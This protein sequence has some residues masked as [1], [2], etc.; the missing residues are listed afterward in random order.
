MISTPMNI[1]TRFEQIPS[2]GH[3]MRCYIAQPEGSE[4]RPGLLLF[5]EAFGVNAHI[6]DV[7]ERLARMGY[8]TIAPELY[9]RTAEPGYEVPY[10]GFGEAAQ[11][12]HAL[13]TATLEA[14]ARAAFE[15]LVEQPTV[16]RSRIGAIGFCLGGRTAYLANA[17]LPLAAAVSYYGG[18]IAPGLLGRAKDQHGPLLLVWGGKDGHITPELRHEISA[19]MQAAGRPCVV[20]DFSE[21]EHGFHCDARAAYHPVAARQAWA[22]TSAFLQDHLGA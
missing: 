21:A 13:S 18:G 22:L 11:H 19:A 17:V 7:A 14:D 5:Q 8:V 1:T 4:R 16:D 6:R 10:T 20:A 12:F 2:D 9:H 3:P 15:Y